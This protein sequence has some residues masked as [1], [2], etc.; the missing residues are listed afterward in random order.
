MSELLSAVGPGS[1]TLVADEIER[2]RD[3]VVLP[4]VRT[5]KGGVNKEWLLT[6]LAEAARE[7]R[8]RSTPT[9]LAFA[10]TERY[11]FQARQT[12]PEDTIRKALFDTSKIVREWYEAHPEHR[13]C[14]LFSTSGRIDVFPDG[15]PDHADARE[16]IQAIRTLASQLPRIVR[17]G[18]GLFARPISPVRITATWRERMARTFGA[19]AVE[20]ASASDLALMSSLLYSWTTHGIEMSIRAFE[21]QII[22]VE[23]HPTHDVFAWDGALQW[24]DDAYRDY[25]LRQGEVIRLVVFEEGAKE[26]YV[27]SNE[28]WQNWVNHIE[29]RLVTDKVR[30]VLQV[31]PEWEAAMRDLLILPN[32]LVVEFEGEDFPFNCWAHKGRAVRS[33]TTAARAIADWRDHDIVFPIERPNA[34]CF[35]ELRRRLKASLKNASPVRG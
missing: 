32:A 5:T 14:V 35:D 33:I 23:R 13:L 3:H 19:D 9:E 24:L 28:Q 25:R 15:L 10:V 11:G 34:E 7:G 20:S 22:A 12:N 26:A 4:R 27:K 1:A 21:G 2:L 29:G 30:V 8:R 18:M 6:L 17:E 16:E 31:L